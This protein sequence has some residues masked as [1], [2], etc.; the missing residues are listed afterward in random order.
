M[1]VFATHRHKSAT[2]AHVSRHPEPHLLPPSPPYP[3]GLS[4]STGFE[5][6]AS[7]I[8]PALIIYCTYGNIHVHVSFKKQHLK[9]HPFPADTEISLASHLS[10]SGLSESTDNSGTCVADVS[11]LPQHLGSVSPCSRCLSH[12]LRDGLLLSGSGSQLSSSQGQGLDQSPSEPHCPVRT[13]LPPSWAP[14]DRAALVS[15]PQFP[16]PALGEPGYALELEVKRAR[17]PVPPL[18]EESCRVVGGAHYGS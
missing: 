17:K 4:Q 9:G 7:C 18:L 8:K 16:L 5:C 3:S 1:V 13:E 10:E 2:G 11:A 15:T 12:P 14:S 6:P